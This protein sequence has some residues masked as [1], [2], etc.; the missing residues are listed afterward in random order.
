M[1]KIGLVLK[2]IAKNFVKTERISNAVGMISPETGHN[3]EF[4]LPKTEK[5]IVIEEIPYISD[6]MENEKWDSESIK[7]EILRTGHWEYYFEF[8][9]GLSTEINCTFNQDTKRLHRFRS[10]LIG[11]TVADLLGPELRESSVLDL[12]CHCGV[13]TFDLAHRG[14]KFVTGIE[15]R[16]KN[17]EQAEFLKRYYEFDNVS[18][19]QGDVCSLDTEK[20]WDVVM[21]LG[22]LYHVNCPVDLV[23]WCFDH[24][25]KFAVIDTIC[26]KDPI[27]AYKV[28]TGKNPDVAI[29]GT[30]SIELH[31]TY[32]AVIDTM[33]EV[34][35]KNVSEVIG[36]C[37]EEI[38]MYS[39]FS[40]RCF[41][42][43]K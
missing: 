18:F 22:I 34:G 41:I 7:S 33:K 27:S 1:S 29:E 36:V 13:M 26:H 17:I 19:E 8:S 24:S 11:E 3:A 43:H 2:K 16:E 31:P 9:H 4:L 38:E 42:G 21:C 32:R 6:R 25:R 12:A 39:D 14:A 20:M 35:F 23:E 10:S 40:R 30:R 37:S 28:V 5:Q 15:Y